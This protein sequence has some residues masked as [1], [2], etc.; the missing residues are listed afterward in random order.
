MLWVRGEIAPQE[1]FLPFST[2]FSIYMYISNLRGQIT[3]SFVK[4]GCSIGIFLS[5]AK[6]DMSKYG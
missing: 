5:F 2:I 1:Q 6:S 3:C 4:F